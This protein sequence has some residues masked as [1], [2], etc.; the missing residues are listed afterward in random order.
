MFQT[1][2]DEGTWKHHYVAYAQSVSIEEKLTDYEREYLRDHVFFKERVL[3]EAKQHYANITKGLEEK[4]NREN[5]HLW[6]VIESSRP[7]NIDDESSILEDICGVKAD[8]RPVQIYYTKTYGYRVS[9]EVRITH[10][11]DYEKVIRRFGLD[12]G[13]RHD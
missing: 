9:W 8:I 10:K 6:E 11:E 4:I 5:P 7:P 13:R 2:M 12:K 3:G 1:L